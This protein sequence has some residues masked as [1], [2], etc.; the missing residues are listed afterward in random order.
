MNNLVR[1]IYSDCPQKTSQ[2]AIQESI[3]AMMKKLDVTENEVMNIL[4]IPD[5]EKRL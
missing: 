5:S 1:E 2:K 3:V 4:D